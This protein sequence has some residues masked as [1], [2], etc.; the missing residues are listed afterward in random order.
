MSWFE[1]LTGMTESEFKQNEFENF[2]L[3]YEKH[4]DK[5][6]ELMIVPISEIK[7]YININVKGIN[8]KVMIINDDIRNIQRTMLNSVILIASNFDALEHRNEKSKLSDYNFITNYINDHTQG[9]TASLCA[10]YATIYR[11]FNPV[12]INM[13]QKLKMYNIINGYA[14]I[15]VDYALSMPMIDDFTMVV[16]KN[17]G[18]TNDLQNFQIVNYV[19]QVFVSAINIKQRET[20]KY[21]KIMG[22][23]YPYLVEYPIYSGYYS[24]YLAGILNGRENLVLTLI[25]GGVFGNDVSVVISSLLKVHNHFK[26]LGFG[27]IKNIYINVYKSPLKVKNYIQSRLSEFNN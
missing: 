16:H 15:R 3:F 9:P 14:S 18:I 20:G 23:K 8:P 22:L 12:K 27:N 6:G 24:A 4:K 10:P 7:K 11:A 19:D 26:S 17:V 21:N 5:C 2:K 13:L 25:G 1:R